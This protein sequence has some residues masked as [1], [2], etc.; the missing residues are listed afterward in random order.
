MLFLTHAL[1]RAG[2]A[3]HERAESQPLRFAVISNNAQALTDV[4]TA[5]PEKA[6]LVALCKVIPQEYQ[7]VLCRSIDVTLPQADTRQEAGLVEALISEIRSD[8]SERLVAYRGVQRW[9]QSYEP[10]RLDAGAGCLREN[11][12]YL[13]TGG[14]GGVGLLLAQ[15]LA[16]TVNARLVLAGRSIRKASEVGRGGSGSALQKR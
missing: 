9:T 10:L 1:E 5:R 8:A 4:E 11:G 14:M 16:Q 15:R 12:V 6:T 3:S 7:N 13:I 2:L